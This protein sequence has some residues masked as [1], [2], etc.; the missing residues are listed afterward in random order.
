MYVCMCVLHGVFE[1]MYASVHAFV[2]VCMC[3]CLTDCQLLNIRIWKRLGNQGGTP[4]E[5]PAATR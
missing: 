3:A 1:C 5:K 2:T 4:L